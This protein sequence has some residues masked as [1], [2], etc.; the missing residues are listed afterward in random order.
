MTEPAKRLKSS[1]ASKFSGV[2]V[3]FDWGVQD[4]GESAGLY[5]QA[6]V[7]DGYGHRVNEELDYENVR[8]HFIDTRRTP[9][10]TEAQRLDEVPSGFVPV[11]LSCDWHK[12][13]RELNSSVIEFSGEVLYK[14]AESVCFSLSEWGRCYVW[15]HRVMRP[16]AVEG[17]REFIRIKPFALNGPHA[18]EYVKRLPK[19]GEDL[20]RAIGEYLIER[21]E[22]LRR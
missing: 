10:R 22:G 19:L 14:L 13:P 6:D 1:F 12:R 18:D 8:T 5:S 7:V 21:G 11:F 16:I 9:V 3:I 17:E 2:A 15:G 20:G 4:R